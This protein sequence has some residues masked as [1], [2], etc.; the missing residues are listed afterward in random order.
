MVIESASNIYEQKDL[1]NVS[2]ETFDN[3]TKTFH[4]SNTKEALDNDELAK[5]VL[6]SNFKDT[7]ERQ[8]L[9][10]AQ[11]V[12]QQICGK[13]NIDEIKMS[14]LKNLPDYKKNQLAWELAACYENKQKTPYEKWMYLRN[15]AI[16]IWKNLWLKRLQDWN[17]VATWDGSWTAWIGWERNIWREYFDYWRS[18]NAERNLYFW[19]FKWPAIVYISAIWEDIKEDGKWWWNCIINFG[20]NDKLTLIYTKEWIKIDTSNSKLPAWVSYD[21]STWKLTIPDS[22]KGNKISIT[23]Q[24]NKLKS[25]Y[26]EVSFNF[27]C[28]NADIKKWIASDTENYVGSDIN[29]WLWKFEISN[30]NE[31][32]QNF[33][34]SV[35]IACKQALNCIW[36]NKITLNLTVSTDKTPFLN[37]EE[38]INDNKDITFDS[39]LNEF[40]KRK[41]Q[42]KD[43]LRGIYNKIPKYD[44]NLN[45]QENA[46]NRL[47]QLRFLSIM[48]MLKRNQIFADAIYSKKLVLN[49]DFVSWD[50]KRGIFMVAE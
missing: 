13:E 12:I 34:N 26:D 43:C 2:S 14:D 20:N 16:K 50:E 42:V 46:Q 38:F 21:E 32:S 18:I 17:S 45:S 25:E 5:D 24:S 28:E 49:C 27:L 47:L 1:L 11:N 23:T 41:D 39:V 9:T 33:K 3:A 4:W 36:D 7:S 22:L 40:W 29:Q 44:A 48:D 8:E 37:P 35:I 30:E 6:L 15:N 10:A 19:P 31:D